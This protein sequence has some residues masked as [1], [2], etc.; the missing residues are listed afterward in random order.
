MPASGR[1]SPAAAWLLAKARPKVASMPMTSPVERISGPRSVSTSGKRLKGSTASLTETWAPGAG[2]LST[3]SARSSA[4]VAPTITRAATLARA[5]PVALATNGTVRLA[6]GLASI[7]YTFSRWTAYCTLSNPLTPSASAM[8]RVWPSIVATTAALSVGGGITQALSPECTPASSTCSMIAPIST[9][10]VAS[11]RA[12][13]STSIASSK[14]RSTSTGRS[15][16]RPP[17]R[18][19]EPAVPPSAE[20]KVASS[21]MARAR[22]LSS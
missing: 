5:T 13:T 10:P 8:A 2:S 17:S 15:A 6:R 7:T 22:F 11:R 16:D 3:P 12:S 14:N 1:R 4:S 20:P 21:A 18:P 19:S 9:S